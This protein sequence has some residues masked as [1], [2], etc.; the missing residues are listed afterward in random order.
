MRL[1]LLR[2]V[3]ITLPV[4]AGPSLAAGLA[5]WGDAPRVLGSVLC[6]VAWG[7]GLLACLA[8]RAVGL[9]T[10]RAVA[11]AAL[12]AAAAAAVSGR[13]STLAA[14]GAIAATLAAVVLAADPMVA[15]W[16]AN[17]SAYSGEHRY[18]LRVPPA[19]FLGPLPLARVVVLGGF[20]VGPLLVADGQTLWGVAAIVLG[21]PIAVFAAGVLHRLSR[22]WLVVVPAGVVVVDPMT[23]IDNV[24][25]T[26]D[27]VQILR[28]VAV[29][30]PRDQRL[31]LRM[32][33]TIGSVLIEFDEPAELTRVARAHRGGETVRAP[34]V[35][36][37]VAHREV[38]L[39][40][41]SRRRVRVE[42]RSPRGGR[43]TD[44]GR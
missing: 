1:W 26:R 35:L 43:G 36:V 27:H 10:L 2:A 3:W 16:A 38:M 6:W 31:D 5:G 21:F 4:S 41:A 8:P 25:F 24:L 15:E 29:D 18:P 30:E 19:L 7:L 17:G 34:S 37:A 44:S 39:E 40:D 33:A 42:V 12:V 23:L 13:P 28:A 11:P 9:T 20:V 32:G 22:R 14:A